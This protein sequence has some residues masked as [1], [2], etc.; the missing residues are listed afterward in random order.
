MLNPIL[1]SCTH[2]FMM[3]KKIYIFSLKTV[4]VHLNLLCNTIYILVTNHCQ[5]L[6]NTKLKYVHKAL[7]AKSKHTA[8]SLNSCA[9]LPPPTDV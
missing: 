3:R 6:E 5:K 1:Q 8:V 4:G 2:V 9:P 7:A